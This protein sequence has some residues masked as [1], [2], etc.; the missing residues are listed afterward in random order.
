MSAFCKDCGMDTEPWPPHRF[1][2]EH[3]VV[4][5]DIWQ[6]A[7]MPLGKMDSEFSLRGG[8]ILCIG[9]IEKHLGRLLTISDFAPCTLDLLKGCQNTPRLLSRA[10][11]ASMAVAC[12]PLPEWSINGSKPH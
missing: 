7:G 2:Q 3:Y 12:N 11:I 1:T 5:D 6:Q 4:K 9:C 10:G 8:G